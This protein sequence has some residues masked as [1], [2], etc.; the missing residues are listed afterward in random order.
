MLTEK[1]ILD[2]CLKNDP[3][4]Q[5]LLFRRFGPKMYGI[6][7]RYVRNKAEASDILQEGFIKV[8]SKLDNFRGDGSF[9]GW[10]QRIFVNTAINHY[11]SNLHYEN[12][13]IEPGD[14]DFV[15]N[16]ALGKLHTEE[17]LILINE[18]PDGYRMVFNLYEI[19][20][21][22]HK[23]I[24][25]MM[26]INETTSRSQLLRAKKSLQEKLRKRYNISCYEHTA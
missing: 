10:V 25:E 6:C 12:D 2:R 4:A 13:Q 23:E 1:E 3:L 11:R 21:F 15:E 26:G 20:G 17:L 7:L 24:A 14:I 8:F 5:E 22:D 16:E 9:E 19:E 18:L